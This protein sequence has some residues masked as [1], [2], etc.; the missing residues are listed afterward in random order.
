MNEHR[1]V[2]LQLEDVLKEVF[3][4]VMSEAEE[5]LEAE[6]ARPKKYRFENGLIEDPLMPQATNSLR[7]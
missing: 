4:A 6:L 7:N 2:R 3:D 5:L 1:E